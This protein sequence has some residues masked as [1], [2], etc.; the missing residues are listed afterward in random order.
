[1]LPFMCTRVSIRE[2]CYSFIFL[3]ECTQTVHKSVHLPRRILTINDWCG[4]LP[5]IFYLLLFHPAK[6]QTSWLNNMVKLHI[7]MPSPFFH[8]MN[9]RAF[10]VST[11]LI[12]FYLVIDFFRCFLFGNDKSFSSRSSFLIS[13]GAHASS[14]VSKQS[15][16]LEPQSR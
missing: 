10:L 11:L 9:W 7:M 12:G 1:M 2:A 15:I 8:F 3:G 13:C 14:V 6:S 4:V 16:Q 5:L